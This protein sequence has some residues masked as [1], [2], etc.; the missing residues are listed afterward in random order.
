MTALARAMF[1]AAL[2]Y[3][4]GRRI[5]LEVCE[6]RLIN[7]RRELACPEIEAAWDDAG[8]RLVVT[9]LG[10]GVPIVLG[11]RRRACAAGWPM[12]REVPS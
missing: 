4:S 10:C 8:D 5:L 6:L 9:A 11:D 7:G 3:A 2:A 12:W 1:L